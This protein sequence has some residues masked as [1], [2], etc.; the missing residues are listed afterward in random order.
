MSTLINRMVLEAALGH[1]CVPA[2]ATSFHTS[3]HVIYFCVP[4]YD[5][6]GKFICGANFQEMQLTYSAFT[7][8]H[9]CGM[10]GACGLPL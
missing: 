9:R 5:S 2:A 6:D 3:D 10:T 7:T 8:L 4:L 1:D